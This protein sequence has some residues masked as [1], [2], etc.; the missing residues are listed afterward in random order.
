M[1]YMLTEEIK[2][3]KLYKLKKSMSG[4]RDKN[5]YSRVQK[6]AKAL[7]QDDPL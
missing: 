7:S 1:H 4:H 6:I 2:Q 3:K 5:A